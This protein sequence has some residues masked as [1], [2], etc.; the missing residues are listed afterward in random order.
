MSWSGFI[1]AS[2]EW[3]KDYPDDPVDLSGISEEDERELTYDEAEEA[4]DRFYK[5][6]DLEDCK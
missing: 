3:N 4:I 1:S 2:K 5:M 6:F